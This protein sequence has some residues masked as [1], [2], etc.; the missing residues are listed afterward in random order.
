MDPMEKAH[1]AMSLALAC[2]RVHPEATVAVPCLTAAVY[3]AM[4][5]AI[6]VMAVEIEDAERLHVV[7][8]H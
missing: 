7:F 8:A 5:E 3:E 1:I 2:A 4:D 6:E